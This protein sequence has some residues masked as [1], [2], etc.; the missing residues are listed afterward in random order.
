MA[1]HEW[2]T[3]S[4]PAKILRL[5][6]DDILLLFPLSNIDRKYR[7]F[8]VNCLAALGRA[9]QRHWDRL[10]TGGNELNFTDTFYEQTDYG[11]ALN[12]CAE[13]VNLGWRK[14]GEP[15][16]EEAEKR[17]RDFQIVKANLV[18]EI[19]GNP[20]QPVDI[21][22]TRRE[23][24]SGAQPVYITTEPG[25]L[26][27]KVLRVGG[28]I[29]EA[30]SFDDMPQF[31]DLLEESGCTNEVILR[32]CRQQEL[33]TF[34]KGAVRDLAGLSVIN[35]MDMTPD[36]DVREA[37]LASVRSGA[38][39]QVKCTCESGWVPKRH[40]CVRGCWVLDLVLGEFSTPLASE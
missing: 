29:Y 13:N 10:E 17:I 24:H 35:W 3:S 34:C 32:H 14:A 40:P 4:D 33:C 9:Q 15:I 25:W 16:S 11:W 12:W 38:M 37:I 6:N 22:N 20:F 21:Y 18:R 23:M 26:T 28:A 8:A 39:C 30:R 36:K 31:G 5:I 19:F 2:L 1:E 27:P 7:A